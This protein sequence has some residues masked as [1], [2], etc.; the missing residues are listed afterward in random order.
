MDKNAFIG[1]GILKE[2]V[3]CPVLGG[4]QHH[5]Y[6]VVHQYR[7]P[8][9]QVIGFRKYLEP[10]KTPV[11]QH[12]LFGY[13]RNDAIGVSQLDDIGGWEHMVHQ[14]IVRR[15]TFCGKKLLRVQ[16]PVRFAELGVPL[17][18]DLPQSII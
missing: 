14:G 12:L 11:F 8:G 17:M 13:R 1:V 6:V 9:I 4:G 16:S 10:L 7:L 15:K 5:L 3:F 2:V 18:G